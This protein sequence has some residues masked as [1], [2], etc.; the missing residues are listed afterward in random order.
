MAVNVKMSKNEEE[1]RLDEMAWL[2]KRIRM[3]EN[4]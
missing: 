2:E 4:G 1:N 3:D